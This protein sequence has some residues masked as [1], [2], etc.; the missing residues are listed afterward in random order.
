MKLGVVANPEPSK[1][2]N[3]KIFLKRVAK[4][5]PYKRQTHN[6][7]F[8]DDSSIN[9]SIK[10]GQWKESVKEGMTLGDLKD[11]LA[12]RYSLD[13]DIADRLVIRYD[14][15]TGE[16]G[17]TKAH[18]IENDNAPLDGWLFDTKKLMVR[19][20]RGDK[21]VLDISCD[22]NF[23]AETMPEV[24]EAIRKAYHWVPSEDRIFLLL[25]NA[26]GHGTKDVV[27]E[28]VNMLEERFNIECIHQCPRSPCTNML[29]LGAWMALQNVV[30]RM[31]FRKRNQHDVLARTVMLAF[32]ELD[33][34]KLE[35]IHKRWV[36]VLHLIIEDEGGDRLVEKRRG[37]L[38]SEPTEDVEDLDAEDGES[39]AAPSEIYDGEDEE[40]ED[41]DDDEEE[42]SNSCGCAAGSLCMMKTTPVQ[43]NEH[44]CFNCQ[45]PMHGALCG[46]LW[47]HEDSSIDCSTVDDALFT[48]V[49]KRKKNSEGALICAKC[50]K[51]CR[52][53]V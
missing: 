5:E 14:L 4:E 28:Y 26:G 38:L 33:P 34:K 29:D 15:S 18:Y 20:N 16:E 37:K 2:F 10:D 9:W 48:A 43:S 51:A 1:D 13:D 21:R 32:D 12:E 3:G 30:Q 11:V 19:Y 7:R 53:K 35:N 40:E 46:S 31:H 27:N 42:E 24:G 44:K 49:G 45:N 41:N 17:K 22:S 50:I 8:T 6:E 39:H 36:K 25:D 23:M 52:K 47:Q